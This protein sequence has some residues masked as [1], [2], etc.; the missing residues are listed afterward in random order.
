[1]LSSLPEDGIQAILRCASGMSLQSRS[2]KVNASRTL[3][4]KTDPESI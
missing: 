2:R 4:V 3:T 1:M